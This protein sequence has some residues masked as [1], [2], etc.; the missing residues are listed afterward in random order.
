MVREPMCESVTI[1]RFATGTQGH[2]YIDI[3]GKLAQF[4]QKVAGLFSKRSL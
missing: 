3:I 1:D 2:T 4:I